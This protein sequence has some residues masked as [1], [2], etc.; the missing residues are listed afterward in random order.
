MRG[1]GRRRKWPLKEK[2][3]IVQIGLDGSLKVTDLCRREDINASQYYAWKRKLLGA[4]T[5]ISDATL[6]KSHE[7]RKSG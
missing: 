1:T 2:L 3:R 4:A 7:P 6:R 5:K